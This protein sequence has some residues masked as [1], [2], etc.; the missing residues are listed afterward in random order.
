MNTGDG[1]RK[2][3]EWEIAKKRVQFRFHVYSYLAV[4][5]FLWGV[6]LISN[7]RRSEFSSWEFPWPIYV[8]LG[9]GIGLFFHYL[10]SYSLVGTRAVEEEYKKLKNKK[11]Q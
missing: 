1:G 6:W 2:D 7:L 4:N 3:P 11:D 10:N 5:A 9:W 8:M